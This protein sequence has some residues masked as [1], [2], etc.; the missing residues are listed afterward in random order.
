MKVK[1]LVVAGAILMSLIAIQTASADVRLGGDQTICTDCGGASCQ[2]DSPPVDSTYTLAYCV[3]EE[4]D[5]VDYFLNGV[6]THS[7]G[8][9]YTGVNLL[10]D[11]LFK[12][13]QV[14]DWSYNGNVV[15]YFKRLRRNYD[16]RYGW[17]FVGNTY[18]NCKASDTEY[19]TTMTGNWSE[20]AMT[21]G[22]YRW[23][24]SAG[25]FGFSVG[26]CQHAYANL[27]QTGYGNGGYSRY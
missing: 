21:Q 27:S 15:T 20:Q 12:Y 14:I 24:A 4:T 17:N 1:Y 11:W 19:C 25:L 26:Y 23:C 3:A 2:T 8:W 13:R 7:R 6:R 16:T 5:T 10:G 22:H 18:S 9:Q